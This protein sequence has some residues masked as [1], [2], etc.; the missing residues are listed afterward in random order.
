MKVTASQAQELKNVLKSNPDSR[1]ANGL[2]HSQAS[3]LAIAI[4]AVLSGCRSFIAIGEWA[5]RCTQ[6]MLKRLGCYFHETKQCYTSP[7]E[8]TIR[9]VLQA[10][11]IEKIEPAFNN[12]LSSLLKGGQDEALAV[13]GKVLKGAHDVDN[14]QVHLLS[15]VLHGQGVT[16]AQQ[17]VESKT[18]EIPALRTLLEPLNIKGRV[19]TVDALHTQ[20]ETAKYLVDEKEAHYLFTVKDNQPTLRADI[21]DLNLDKEESHFETTD[22]GHGRVESRK[23]WVSTELND[24]L[25]FPYVGQVFCIN[26]HV[27]DC[28]KQ[29]EREE[30]VYGITDLTPKEANP[31]RLLKLNREH[32]EIENRSHYVRDVTFDEDRSQ[33]RTQNGPQVMASLRN[34]AIGTLRVIKKAENIASALRDIAAKPRLALQMIGL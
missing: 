24:Y 27:Y 21:A 12:W 28:K 31:E 4:C 8:P 11:D 33:V 14:K 3:V 9:R 26:R 13:D 22:K 6:N 1:K 2:R 15:G 23:I 5:N 19:V 25:D 18:N 29:G 10:G 16:I 7:S 20:K 30:T 32:W 17:R 34:F